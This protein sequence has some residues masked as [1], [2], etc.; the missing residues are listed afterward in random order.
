[1]RAAPRTFRVD[2]ILDLAQTD[3]A[4]DL[5]AAFDIHDYLE[6]GAAELRGRA[7]AYA[8]SALGASFA[9]DYQHNWDDMQEQPDGSVVVTMTVPDLQWA[10]STALAYGGLAVVEEPPELRSLVREW[11]ASVVA[12][13]ASDRG[14]GLRPEALDT[15][16][17]D[18][19]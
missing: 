3:R 10:A 19:G 1:M 5:P 18:E 13:H 7:G 9:R 12:Q 6:R 4:F 2:R 16:D 14:A 11:A 8:L 17:K 15:H